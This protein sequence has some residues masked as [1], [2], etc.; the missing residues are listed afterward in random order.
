MEEFN[1]IRIKL[2]PPPYTA[3]TS[4][5]KLTYAEANQKDMKRATGFITA[6]WRMDCSLDQNIY[7]SATLLC[8]FIG[9]HQLLIS[10]CL[11]R[12]L[13][14][15]L[16]T[17]HPGFLYINKRVEDYG[18]KLLHTTG[19]APFSG[20]LKPHFQGEHFHTA[21][22]AVVFVLVPSSTLSKEERE[23]YAGSKT[24]PASIKEKET[25][26]PE[27][28]WVS[29]TRRVSRLYLDAS[30]LFTEVAPFSW[31]K[32]GAVVIARV[33]FFFSFLLDRDRPKHN[34]CLL[35]A[36]HRSL[37]QRH[38]LATHRSL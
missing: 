29:P 33:T 17:Q 34:S 8:C 11:W 1:G 36:L 28:P 27:V 4:I 32:W 30:S 16:L 31:L 6:G 37:T 15:D 38:H 2:T 35:V 14:V 26:W 24:L 18:G 22:E 13:W 21:A 20:V 10:Q 3:V 23:Y 9:L 25:H 12:V 7:V 5:S 19:P